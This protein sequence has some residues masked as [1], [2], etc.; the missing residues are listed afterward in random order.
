[1]N[2]QAKLQKMGGYLSG[3]IIPAIGIIIAW[4]ILTMFFIPAGFWPNEAIATI[5]GPTITYLIPLLVGYTGGTIFYKQRGGVLGAFATMGTI[6]ASSWWVSKSGFFPGAKDQNMLLGAMIA[7]PLS[8]I[9]FK[10]IESLWIDKIPA[11][12]EM[13]IN[14]FTLAIFGIFFVLIAMFALAPAI[15]WLV[16]TLGQGA[17]FIQ[18]QGLL[19][20]LSF[21]VEPAKPFFLN[22]AIGNGTLVPIAINQ[23]ETVGKSALFFV[24]ANPGPGL[25]MLG[26]FAFFGSRREKVQSS[27]ALP[28]HFIGGIHEVYFPFVL[29]NLKIIPVLI[30]SGASGIAIMQIFGSGL[31]AP[32]SPGSIIAALASTAKT[33]N[34]YIGVG[35]AIAISAAISFIGT[36]LYLKVRKKE[37]N[38]AAGIAQTH[39]LKGKKSKY[40]PTT[41]QIQLINVACDQGA[42]SSAL[43]KSVLQKILKK[44]G[45]TGIKI[46]NSAIKEIDQTADLVITNAAFQSAAQKYLG[47]NTLYCPVDNFLSADN[48]QEVINIIINTNGPGQIP[49][50]KNE[51]VPIVAFEKSLFSRHIAPST[52][53]KAITKSGQLLLAN[54]KILAP[55]IEGMIKRNKDVSVA[56]GNG[57]AL[58]HG[59][60]EN[61]KDILA[62]GLSLSLY[63]NG[64]NWKGKRVYVVIGLAAQGSEHL[65]YL[66]MIAQLFGQAHFAKQL[67]QARNVEQ[68]NEIIANAYS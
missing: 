7:G 24:E 47:T 38:L 53:Q 32:M 67:A 20:L 50:E 40:L 60:R 12:Y 58:P 64:I 16:I 30:L 6:A 15:L 13:L 59:Q 5:V 37:G 28:I 21:L 18:K 49:K 22:N 19:P 39:H 9:A 45:L 61:K 29:T 42:G 52:P 3:M 57:L 51:G 4:G 66:K 43:G 25:G 31:V 62:T 17:N 26:A 34:D 41:S 27:G 8:A 35:L 10:K 48:F 56:L 54:Q 44:Q 55:Y 11:G 33:T 14:N 1:M 36:F 63:P 65:D 68:A 2:W 23:T 46:I